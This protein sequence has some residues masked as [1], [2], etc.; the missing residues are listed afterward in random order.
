MK[1]YILILL[2]IDTAIVGIPG[3]KTEADCIA[4][5]NKAQQD[6]ATSYYPLK[7]SCVVKP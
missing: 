4:A 1:T 3:F 6:F 5:G 7:F 2:M